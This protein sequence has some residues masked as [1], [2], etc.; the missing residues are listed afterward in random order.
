MCGGGGAKPPDVAAPAAKPAAISSTS[1]TLDINTNT[2]SV[3][4]AKSNKGVKKFKGKNVVPVNT[5]VASTGLNIPKNT[6]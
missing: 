1:P 3:K 6:S 4:M 2:A 5:N